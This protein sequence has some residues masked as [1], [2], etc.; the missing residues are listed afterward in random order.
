M[1]WCARCAADV[2]CDVEVFECL[3]EAVKEADVVVTVTLATEP[4]LCGRWLK[5]GAVVC[6]KISSVYNI[7]VGLVVCTCVV[8]SS[9]VDDFTCVL[10]DGVWVLRCG[11]V[12]ASL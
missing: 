9:F 1:L 3:E 4:I 5:T 8:C 7:H 6:C 2:E 11:G 10:L 12:S